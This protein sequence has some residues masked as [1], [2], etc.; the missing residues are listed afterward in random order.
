MTTLS[1][2]IT[3]NMD[4]STEEHGTVGGAIIDAI[5]LQSKATLR[6]YCAVNPE[7]RDSVTEEE[8]TTIFEHT[9]PALKSFA[10]GTR[11]DDELG[12][13]IYGLCTGVHYR[14][15]KLRMNAEKLDASLSLA[16]RDFD[17]TEIANNQIEDMTSHL[18][19]MD[20]T[21]NMLGDLRQVLIMALQTHFDMRWIPPG[22]GSYT[23]R[24]RKRTSAFIEAG[25]Y[26]NARRKAAMDESIPKGTF[27][28]FAGACDFG[29]EQA[30]WKAL[31][32]IHKDYPDMI[33]VHTGCNTGA[34]LI[35]DKWALA[36]AVTRIA[37]KPKFDEHGARRAPFER[38]RLLMKEF[39][40]EVLIATP[41]P[42]YIEN[43]I[44]EM[45]R[46][47]RRVV[48]IGLPKRRNQ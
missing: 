14:R 41:G 48:R 5:N 36:K 42:G 12:N 43:L 8:F 23:H 1:T 17:G 31:D 32:Q 35:A 9:I 29:D 24:A 21:I 3:T 28:A 45:H 46:K 22:S 15:R 40:P 16:H 39:S 11:L 38:N 10:E 20:I 30:V 7:D 27:I 19:D 34:D 26:L 4:Y 44:D 18:K 33:L 47:N 37:V 13:I 6:D 2:N 25:D